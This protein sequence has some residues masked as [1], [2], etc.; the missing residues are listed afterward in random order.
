MVSS[1]VTE[2]IASISEIASNIRGLSGI[3]L[4]TELKGMVSRLGLETRETLQ[5]QHGNLSINVT[6]NVKIDAAE[7]TGVLLGKAGRKFEYTE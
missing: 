6:F 5:I 7:L 4:N 3:N 1:T 2:T